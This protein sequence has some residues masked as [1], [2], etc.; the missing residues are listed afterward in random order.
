ML[1]A[2]A[3]LTPS[4]DL[5]IRFGRFKVP[6]SADFLIPL[7]NHPLTSRPLL[8]RHAP[9][10]R[11]GA[12]AN[13]RFRMGPARLDLN[14][15]LFAENQTVHTDHG[16]LLAARAALT[17]GH[18]F[19][20]HVGYGQIVFSDN[21]VNP[22]TGG[23]PEPYDHVLDLALTYEDEHILSHVEALMVFDGPNHARCWGATTMAGYTFGDREGPLA[24]QPV[25]SYDLW[26]G[27]LETEHRMGGGLNLQ[28]A[29][30]RV[31]LRL[32]YE[33]VLRE[34]RLG[35]ATMFEVQVSF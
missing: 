9:R 32:D 15:G 21:E 2:V 35:H 8:V 27:A 22:A 7:P 26:R 33:A 31:I 4:H 20:V 11:L 6:I 24:V 12:D 13:A 34:E 17:W 5:T 25:L 10:R 1:D 3:A 16:K 30:S 23:R 14:L 29:A 18:A 28:L 19:G